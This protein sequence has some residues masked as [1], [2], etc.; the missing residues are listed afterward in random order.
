MNTALLTSSLVG[1]AAGYDLRFVGTVSST[2]TLL[3]SLAEEGAPEGLCLIAES[4]TGGRGRRGRSFFSPEGCGAYVSLLLRPSLAPERAIR[5]TTA[6][7]VAAARSAEAL[8]GEPVGIKWVN[9]LYLHGRKVCGI[10]SE[11]AAK[12]EGA[13]S[14]CVL[15]VGANVLPPPDGFPPELSEIAGSLLATPL[16]DARERF[17]AGFLNAF[18]S[19]Y[20]GLAEGAHEAEYRARSFVPGHAVTVLRGGEARPAFALGVDSECRLRVRYPDGTEEA[21]S[22]GEISIRLAD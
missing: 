12:R 11:A 1:A 16:P 10:L 15:G 5:I 6:A 19:L 9:D 21:L 20:A 8:C 18:A 2:N 4:Q 14:Y 17:L 13:L 7:A 22:S 3:R